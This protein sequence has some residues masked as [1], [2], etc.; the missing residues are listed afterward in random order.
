MDK[1]PD[2]E[3]IEEDT[4]EKVEKAEQIHIDLE[5]WMIALLRWQPHGAVV[6][7]RCRY[8]GYIGRH[9]DAIKF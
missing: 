8:L 3:G 7:E 2:G 4:E 5:E 6:H 9:L 1:P